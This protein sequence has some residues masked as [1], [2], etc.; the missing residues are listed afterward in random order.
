VR[1][2]PKSVCERFLGSVRR[3]CLDHILVASER[4]AHAVL[5]EYRRYFNEARPHQALGQTVPVG[6]SRGI[7]DRGAVI[8]EPILNGAAPRL[9]Q[10]GVTACPTTDGPNSQHGRSPWRSTEQWALECA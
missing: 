6:V 7:G 4:H 9:P 5:N 8:G 3:E 1:Q 10:G 2:K